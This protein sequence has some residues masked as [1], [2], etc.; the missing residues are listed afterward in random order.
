MAKPLWTPTLAQVLKRQTKQIKRISPKTGNEYTADVI[1][2]AVFILAGTPEVGEG[3]VKYPIADT[4]HG[5]EYSIKVES[6]TPLQDVKFAQQLVFKNITGGALSNG[7]GW[8]K[9]E[10]V[11]KYVKKA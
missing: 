6:S 2:Q 5:L 3:F 10:G 4:A 9:A 1:E 8:Y 7:N 11:E